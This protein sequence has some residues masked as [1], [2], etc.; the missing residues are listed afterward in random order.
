MKETKEL[1]LSDVIDLYLEHGSIDKVAYELD[2]TRQHIDNEIK[3]QL[4][5]ES[6]GIKKLVAEFYTKALKESEG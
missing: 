2:C 5:I 4:N 6:G 3:R 1:N